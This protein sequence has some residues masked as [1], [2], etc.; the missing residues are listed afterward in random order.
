MNKI[1]IPEL[2]LHSHFKLPIFYNES[3]EKINSEIINDL[4]LI[5]SNNDSEEPIYDHIFTPS[6]S[7]GKNMLTSFSEY[8]TN[9]IRFL[10]DNQKML[11]KYSIKNEILSPHQ[12][13][14]ILTA[15][16]EIKNETGFCEKY[17]YI[18]WEFGKFLN[19]NSVFLQAMSVYNIT[20]PVLS[21]FLPIF[22][23]IVPFFIIKL[24]GLH[25]TMNQYL[26]VLK[27]IAVN[28]AIGKIFTKFNEVDN[29]Q[30][31]YILASAAFYIFSIY[32]NI[33]VC[34]RFYSNTKKIHDYLNTFKHYIG[35]TINKMDYYLDITKDLKTYKD[36]NTDVIKNKNILLEYKNNLDKITPFKLS[37][38]KILNMGHILKTF[39][40]LYDNK[41]YNDS[42]LYSFGFNGYLDNISGLSNNISNKKLNKARFIPKGKGKGVNKFKKAFYPNLIN[43]SPV[44]NSYDLNKNILITGPNAS[45]KTT[46]LKTTLINVILSQQIGFGCFAS[47]KISPFKFIHCYLNIPDTS[48]RDSLFQAEARRCKEIIDSIHKNPK[49]SH[50][51]V[52]DE[53]YSGTNPEEASISA[54]AFMEYITKYKTVSCLLTTHYINLCKNLSNN[55]RIQ[56]YN[57][58]TI[59]TD[60]SFKYTYML[61]EGISEI[62]GGL[63]VLS[64]MNY[65]TE[66][67]NKTILG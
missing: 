57:M 9:D 50:F 33:L 45:G 53:L 17:L 60:D 39:Y 27:T 34:I 32:Q 21:L 62:K 35:E 23:L 29:S 1:N 67:L 66:I 7:L 22:I 38:S 8:Y 20:S 15:W 37:I 47:A 59:K 40:E 55:I 41:E 58:K 46:L 4:E 56:N 48:A 14:D 43:K 30:K 52:F 11:L 6:T 5:R 12:Y 28:H 10:K 3:K 26:D 51:C 64:D 42:L 54:Q 44:K 16:N 31:I 19:T 65:P 36:F 13:Q 18:D 2:D 63:K 25:I 49:E 61:I 24:K